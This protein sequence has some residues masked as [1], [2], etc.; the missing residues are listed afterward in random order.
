LLLAAAGPA[1][2]AADAVLAPEAAAAAEEEADVEVGVTVASSVPA[3]SSP[4]SSSTDWPPPSA[5][6]D[7]TEKRAVPDDEAA[8]EAAAAAIAL[9]TGGAVREEAPVWG[10]SVL[11]CAAR[12]S[13]PPPAHALA[14]AARP[15][16][17][18]PAF[19]LVIPRRRRDWVRKL[20]GSLLS[21]DPNR[22]GAKGGEAWNG[23]GGPPLPLIAFVWEPSNPARPAHPWKAADTRDDGASHAMTT[24]RRRKRGREWAGKRRLPISVPDANGNDDDDNADFIGFSFPPLE[25][26]WNNSKGVVE[27]SMER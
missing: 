3:L 19:P 17:T 20:N 18:D 24:T 11:P 7:R 15:A 2:A 14:F 6:P 9:P 1:A 26:S 25:V 12:R 4:S 27:G 23:V 8:A 22:R 13:V 10:P 21:D 5:P 16:R